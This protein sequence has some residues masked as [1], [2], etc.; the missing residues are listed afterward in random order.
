[1]FDYAAGMA[2]GI[3]VVGRW[4]NGLFGRL[5]RRDIWLS[6]QLI[7]QVRARDGDAATGR[8]LT[9]DFPTEQEAR[10]MVQRLMAATD[11]G[12]WRELP[13]SEGG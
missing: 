3:D 4:W 13:A 10:A 9:W 11:Q 8:E 1:M 2:A 5:S 6:R 7:W 12:R